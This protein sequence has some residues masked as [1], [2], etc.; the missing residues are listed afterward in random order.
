MTINNRLW[1]A[2]VRNL[3]PYVPG[4]QSKQENLCKLNTNENPFAPSPKAIDAMRKLLADDGSALRLYPEPE[5]T[6]LRDE[7]VKYYSQY[8]QGF[9]HDNVFVGNGSDEVLALIFSCFFVKDRPLLMPDISYSFYPVYAQHYSIT[10]QSIPLKADFSIDTDDYRMPC[11]GIILA[12]PNAPTGILLG[13]DKIRKLASEHPNSV[14]V[15]DEAYIDYADE[16][17]AMSA[18]GLIHEF[19]NIVVVQTFSKSRALAGLRVGMAFACP[20]LITALTILKNSFNSYPLDVV[21]QTGAAASI[22]DVQYF[23]EKR[24]EVIHL[25]NKLEKSLT[26]LGFEVLPSATNFIFAKPN[27]KSLSAQDIANKLR[28]QGILIRHFNHARIKDYLRITVGT[29]EQNL[30]LIQ[31]LQELIWFA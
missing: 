1:S 7:I 10:T 20:S 2:K 14:I 3:N 11:G 23:E 17:K 31:A 13:L 28:E 5:S 25:R 29:A 8:Y 19:D 22:A 15:I 9:T 26:A 24:L 21:A 30:R 6:T 4:E 18:M 27:H 12:N 16:P